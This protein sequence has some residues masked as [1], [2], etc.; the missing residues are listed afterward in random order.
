MQG[1]YKFILNDYSLDYKSRLLH[2][3]ILPMMQFFEINDILF[4]I[5]SLKSPIHFQHLQFVIFNTFTTLSGSNYKLIHKHCP[6]SL[7][8]HFYFNRIIRLWNILLT[9]ICWSKSIPKRTTYRYFWDQF[10]TNF[11][12]SNVHTLHLLCPCNVCSAIPCNSTFDNL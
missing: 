2:T 11:D 6:S 1:N 5:R 12:F 3:Q 10:E 8:R 7:Y 9:Y 4:L